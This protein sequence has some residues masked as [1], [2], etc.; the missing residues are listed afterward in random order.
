MV[1]TYDEIIAETQ[2]IID[3]LTVVRFVDGRLSH[4]QDKIMQLAG[5]V[6]NLNNRGHSDKDDIDDIISYD[7]ELDQIQIHKKGNLEVTW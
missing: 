1:L 7:S 6:Q 5:I 3:E 4:L 2:E